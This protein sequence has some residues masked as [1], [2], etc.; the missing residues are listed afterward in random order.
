M[1]IF[2]PE[3]LELTADLDL[4]AFWAENDACLGF[5]TAKPRCALSFCPDDHWLFEFLD[6][7][8]TLRYYHDKPYRDDLHRQ[9]NQLLREYVGRAFFD[10]DSWETSPKRIENLF[11]CEFAYVEGG[12]PWLTPPTDD[13]DEF[14]RILDR[15]E[16]TDLQTWA[17]PDDF[18]EEWE[19]R[20]A[21][22]KTLPALGTGGRGPATI[23]TSVLPT[24]TV[25]FWL[26][27]HPDLMAR[28][29]DL[30]AVKMIELNRVLRAFSGYQVNRLVDHR[31]Q[32]R[33]VQPPLS[34]VLRAGSPRR[35]DEFA[36]P[37]RAATSIPTAPWA[38]C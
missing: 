18:R 38:T 33:A 13:P 9:A 34:P 24:E 29:R 4:P 3:F 22:G 2:D 16:K 11:G 8:S 25:F 7:E 28:F 5:T 1:P 10:E 31:R 32:L 36:P 26:Y 30:L 35:A 37:A 12:T 21:A 27:D 14:S 19:T 20:K 6:V 17:L 23:M 15:A